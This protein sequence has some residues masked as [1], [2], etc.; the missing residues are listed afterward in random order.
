[1]E[2]ANR[3]WKRCPTPFLPT[4]ETVSGTVF[5]PAKMN[6]KNGRSSAVTVPAISPASAI[7]HQKPWQKLEEQR[8]SGERF[9]I[10]EKSWCE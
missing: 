9:R 6:V 8:G 1:M 3:R 5:P 7:I 2:S 4:E 10:Q